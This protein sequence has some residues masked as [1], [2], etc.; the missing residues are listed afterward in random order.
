MVGTFSDD[1]TTLHSCDAT[2]GEKT[3]TWASVEGNVIN[4]QLSSGKADWAPQEGTDVIEFEFN[5]DKQ[6]HAI[7]TLI[8]AGSAVDLESD[9]LLLWFYYVKGKGDP[10]FQDTDALRVRVSDETGTAPTDWGE[11]WF[12]GN[13]TL[14][15]GPNLLVMSGNS[16]ETDAESA[17]APDYTAIRRFTVRMDVFN[18]NNDTGE[19]PLA[20]DYLRYGTGITVT[21][22]TTG[23]PVTEADFNANY[24]ALTEHGVFDVQENFIQQTCRVNIGNGTT[25][26]VVKI[27]SKYI[28]I[29]QRSDEVRHNWQV[30]NNGTLE[31]GIKTSGTGFAFGGSGCQL[32]A[33]SGGTNGFYSPD[34][35]VLGNSGI[36]R[37][38]GTLLR[39]FNDV[40]MGNNSQD[41]ECELI[42]CEIA[43]H[44]IC[45]F[46]TTDVKVLR[47]KIHDSVGSYGCEINTVA[48]ASFDGFEDCNVYSNTTGIL[49]DGNLSHDKL[50]RFLV[51][52]NTTGMEYNTASFAAAPR[53]H[54]GYTFSGNTTDIEN[55]D[56]A[57]FQEDQSPDTGN[58]TFA[59]GESGVRT[60]IGM[61][62][63]MGT[64][65]TISN[66]SM[67]MNK[68][69]SPTGDV[70]LK[71][72]NNA[73]SF[74]GGDDEPTG[75]P[76]AISDPVD[77]AD[78]RTTLGKQD[79]QFSD[80]VQL[81]TGGDGYVLTAEYAN[82]SSTN[83]IEVGADNTSPTY[84]G[85]SCVQ[86]TAGGAWTA[87]FQSVVFS[88]RSGAILEINSANSSS[89]ASTFANTGTNTGA[90]ILRQQ[91]TIGVTGVTPGT[92]VSIIGNNG[93]TYLNTLAFTPDGDNFSAT[94]NVGLDA[95]VAVTV[96]A[97]S[98]GKPTAAY[99]EDTGALTD[100]TV[101][102][103]DSAANMTLLP[104][105]SPALN[106]AYYFGHQE[107]FG[108]LL[109][110]IGTAGVGDYGLT[111]EY[112]NGTIWTALS[113]VTDDTNN[114]KNTGENVVSWTIPG[115]WATIN[116]PGG[117]GTGAYYYVR[118]RASSGTTVTTS[119]IG[120][121]VTLDVTKYL[122]FVQNTQIVPSENLIVQA[123]WVRDTTASFRSNP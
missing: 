71:I 105:V 14:F 76:L 3:G 84:A 66:C 92:R 111:W 25:S 109:L 87:T 59:L 16:N 54:D 58:T 49:I 95:T 101:E 123:T 50:L 114:W 77:A 108:Q 12:G 31:L 53:E 90:T 57:T 96:R 115:N 51:A 41:P 28:F 34:F 100:E 24:G 62:F 13:D 26:T 55:S 17:T 99:S 8:D 29:N 63:Q 88:V 4:I 93:I 43:D 36:C 22:G 38:Y 39:G 37:L 42:D 121:K 70:V 64:T 116:I 52:D 20:L 122:P 27:E 56:D 79:F 68:I 107:Q 18:D 5:G 6:F 110:D 72:Y 120:K 45:R 48:G 112:Y 78:I 89:A 46:R 60:G 104:Q 61:S 83:Y 7:S 32:V 19:S 118:G 73:N 86:S 106:D 11:F 9:D 67:Q 69:G 15:S 98:S 74:G 2:D 44:D 82:G 94:V 1:Y 97:R 113:G 30:S 65:G 117:G 21:D 102:A 85:N 80:K 35:I 10:H 33:R 81:S 75:D 47:T 91:S 23:T 103:N 119:P 40:L